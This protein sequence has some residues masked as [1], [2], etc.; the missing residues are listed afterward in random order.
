MIVSNITPANLRLEHS[1]LLIFRFGVK[2]NAKNKGGLNI[3]GDNFGDYPQNIIL[4][5]SHK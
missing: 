5:I 2:E 1:D 3:F 4:T